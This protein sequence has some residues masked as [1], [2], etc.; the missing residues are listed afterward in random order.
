MKLLTKITIIA[1]TTTAIHASSMDSYITKKLQLTCVRPAHINPS[2]ADI[3][4]PKNFDVT[5]KLRIQSK[6][7]RRLYLY[8]RQDET[9]VLHTFTCPD[10]VE[11]L[12]S[13]EYNTDGTLIMARTYA[14]DTFILG[15]YNTYLIDPTSGKL[16]TKL[17]GK[18]EM[19][20]NFDQEGNVIESNL[21]L[22]VKSM[23][24]PAGPRFEQLSTD[25]IAFLN[26]ISAHQPK[27]YEAVYLSNWSS[28]INNTR[29]ILQTFSPEQQACVIQAFNIQD[30]QPSLFEKLKNIITCKWYQQKNKEDEE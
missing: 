13:A 9:K 4:T 12:A 6:S 17:K 27:G 29:K 14:V 7:H 8:D 26:T 25:Q 10:E 23:L 28:N 2:P 5:P 1:M 20:F 18:H 22:A 11:Q 15:S 16:L 19:Y 21:K 30:A 3:A 24:K